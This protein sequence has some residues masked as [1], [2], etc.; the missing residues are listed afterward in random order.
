MC[1]SKP[2]KFL[3]QIRKFKFYW[4]NRR[5]FT[6]PGIKVWTGTRQVR[7]LPIPRRKP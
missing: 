4:A 2:M 1:V 7:I 5:L 3:F 6:H